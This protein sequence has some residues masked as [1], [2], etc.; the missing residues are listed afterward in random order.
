M[1]YSRVL[2]G[3]PGVVQGEGGVSWGNPED[4]PPGRLG[5]SFTLAN[6]RAE[7][8]TPKNGGGTKMSC[9]KLV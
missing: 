5:E 8:F 1:F 6:S 3:P 9:W 7:I 4:F 2:K